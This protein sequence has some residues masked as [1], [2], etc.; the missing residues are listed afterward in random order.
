MRLRLPGLPPCP[1]IRPSPPTCDPTGK[2]SVAGAH[3]CLRIRFGITATT[4]SHIPSTR[5]GVVRGAARSASAGVAPAAAAS[6]VAAVAAVV[7]SATVTAAGPAAG[8]GGRAVQPVARSLACGMAAA[9]SSSMMISSPGPRSPKH[10][11]PPLGGGAGEVASPGPRLEAGRGFSGLQGGELHQP[12]CAR[13][14]PPPHGQLTSPREDGVTATP[15]ALMLTTASNMTATGTGLSPPGPHRSD[16][17]A[18]EPP[19][20]GPTASSQS[21]LSLNGEWCR[22]DLS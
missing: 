15:R 18:A 13:H 11:P 20:G 19:G 10:A 22:S 7:A 9:I 17:D 16:E 4:V 12:E 3:A 14:V 8:L 1:A 2:L 5:C 21:L 6:A